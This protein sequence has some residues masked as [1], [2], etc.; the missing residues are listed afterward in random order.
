MHILCFYF[1]G[2]EIQDYSKIPG[3]IV[4]KVSDILW[5]TSFSHYFNE[6]YNHWNIIILSIQNV[7]FP[8]ITGE[9]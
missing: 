7:L 6:L 8:S 1:V 3:T 9:K 4:L 2:A 5:C